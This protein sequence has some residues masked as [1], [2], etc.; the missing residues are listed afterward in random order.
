MN[1][2]TYQFAY[3]KD[4]TLYDRDIREP[5]FLW[6]EEKYGMVR[7][8]EEKQTGKARADAVMVTVDELIGIEI[9]SDADTYT[10]LENQVKY[11]DWYY[12]RNYVVVGTSHAQHIAEHVPAW[13]GI[14]TAEREADRIDFYEMRQPQVNPK[15]KM[16]RKITLLWRPELVRIQKRNHL[17]AY[18]EKAKK[19]VQERILAKIPEE[20]LHREISRELFERDYTLIEA[21]LEEYRQR[22]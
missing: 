12:D 1:A 8:I 13:W 15:R 17:P 6:L 14:I 10:R 4:M 11:Y 20:Q 3:N 5:L 21:E 19:F 16:K 22:K 18:K 9:K 7:I 2:H